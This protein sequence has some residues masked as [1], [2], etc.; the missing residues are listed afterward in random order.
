MTWIF[1]QA[2]FVTINTILWSLSYYEVRVAHPKEDVQSHLNVALYCIE[3]AKERWP[4]VSSAIELYDNLIPACMKI[5]DKDGDIPIAANSPAAAGPDDRSRT[6]S[7]VVKTLLPEFSSLM[8][9]AAHSNENIAPF[10]YLQQRPSFHSASSSNNQGFGDNLGRTSLESGISMS[11]SSTYP[12]DFSTTG[13]Y[14]GH[15]SFSYEPTFDSSQYDNPLPT[16][17]NRFDWNPKFGSSQGS[18]PANIP[19]LSPFDQPSNLGMGMDSLAPVQY[20]D[21]LYPPSYDHDRSAAGLNYEQ[22]SELMQSLEM[23]GSGQIQN[24]ISAS[25]QVF[26]PHGRGY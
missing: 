6:T 16:S 17:F 9:E 1:T 11:T 7:P 21:Y 13:S 10:G 5:Y 25:Q 23:T 15:S 24:M 4:G 18:P 3:Q 14:D 2:I 8:G 20:S 12:T 22:H 26:Y 19:A